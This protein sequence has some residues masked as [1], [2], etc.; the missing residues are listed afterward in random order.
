L[1]KK[2][3]KFITKKIDLAFVIL[4]I[5]AKVFWIEGKKMIGLKFYSDKVIMAMVKELPQPKWS[6]KYQMVIAPNSKHNLDQIFIEFK[7]WAYLMNG[8]HD[9][10]I[11]IFETLG[12]ES[13]HAMKPYVQLGY[14]Y[15]LKGDI[16]TANA[17]LQKLKDEA[18]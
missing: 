10:A 14:A 2:E 16:S 1:K 3:S 9:K 6:V 18:K 5:V 13:D 15:A 17:Y 12:N 8:D 11:E 7:G 4:P